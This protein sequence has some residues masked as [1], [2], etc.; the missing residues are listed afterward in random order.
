MVN[1]NP[2][3]MSFFVHPLRYNQHWAYFPG[4]FH[5]ESGTTGQLHCVLEHSQGL[6]VCARLASRQDQI[7]LP[8]TRATFAFSTYRSPSPA[9]YRDPS[10]TISRSYVRSC[11]ATTCCFLSLDRSDIP[12]G[13]RVEI[14]RVELPTDLNHSGHLLLP[15]KHVTRPRISYPHRLDCNIESVSSRI[16]EVIFLCIDTSLF[17]PKFD[18]SAMT[19]RRIS[20]L[21]EFLIMVMVLVLDDVASSFLPWPTGGR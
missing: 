16:K 7:L 5:V 18:C 10:T 21:C 1:P 9:S 8:Q 17:P 20:F 2:E 19:T 6:R 15:K 13:Q 12:N 14:N 3:V 11:Q 4:S